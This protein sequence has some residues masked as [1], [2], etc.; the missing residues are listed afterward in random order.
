MIYIHILCRK[1]FSFHSLTFVVILYFQNYENHIHNRI[2]FFSNDYELVFLGGVYTGNFHSNFLSNSRI[3]SC[4]QQKWQCKGQW[5]RQCDSFKLLKKLP[6]ET[7]PTVFA[8]KF[9]N[10]AYRLIE[11]NWLARDHVQMMLS[12]SYISTLKLFLLCMPWCYQ[13]NDVDVTFQISSLQGRSK[14]F[15]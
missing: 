6:A 2:L 12:V 14:I 5:F 13:W 9:Y 3:L 11:L 4:C 15:S 8:S 1:L 10:G 7:V